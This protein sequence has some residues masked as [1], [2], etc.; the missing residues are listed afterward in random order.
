[1]G[2]PAENTAGWRSRYLTQNMI[3]LPCRYSWCNTNS[4]HS[5]WGEWTC[6]LL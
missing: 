2:T 4:P 6:H 3:V 5:L 1:V